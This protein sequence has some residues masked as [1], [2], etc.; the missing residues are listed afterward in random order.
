MDKLFIHS[1]GLSIDVDT[2]PRIPSWGAGMISPINPHNY[3][4]LHAI[5]N[6]CPGAH[7]HLHVVI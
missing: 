3:C 1:Y 2:Y 4:V 5:L 7:M 6:R